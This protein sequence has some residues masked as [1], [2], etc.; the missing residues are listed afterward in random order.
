VKRALYY[1]IRT[2]SLY[3]PVVAVTSEKGPPG[4]PSRWYGREIKHDM[5][6]NGVMSDLSGRFEDVE[7]AIAMRSSIAELA[8]SYDNVRKQVHNVVTRLYRQEREAME[9]LLRGEEPGALPVVTTVK[10]MW[11]SSHNSEW[12]ASGGR[13]S[14]AT[15]SNTSQLGGACARAAEDLN[16]YGG[17]VIVVLPRVNNVKEVKDD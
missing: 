4:A 11:I 13:R 12:I 3:N 15:G 9:R 7:S 10:R 17:G 6:T 14:L 1:A 16:E 5:P 2:G 8:D